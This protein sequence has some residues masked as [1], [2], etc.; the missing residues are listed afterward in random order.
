M[1]Y[2]GT[3]VYDE[4]TSSKSTW[5]RLKG[6]L[7]GKDDEAGTNYHKLT[8]EGELQKG[9]LAML[10]EW[11]KE[12]LQGRTVYDLNLTIDRVFNR[13]HDLAAQYIWPADRPKGGAVVNQV[14][15]YAVHV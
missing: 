14:N 6:F 5:G 7:M 1:V 12:L 8:K 9:M 2:D 10:P 15:L 3:L 13:Q 11:L 4:S